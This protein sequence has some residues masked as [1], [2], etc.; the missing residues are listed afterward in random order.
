MNHCSRI[1]IKSHLDQWFDWMHLHSPLSIDISCDDDKT[2]PS[3]RSNFADSQTTRDARSAGFTLASDQQQ[4][5]VNVEWKSSWERP[6]AFEASHSFF[7]FLSLCLFA[8]FTRTLAASPHWYRMRL[9]MFPYLIQEWLEC[10]SLKSEAALHFF[11]FLPLIHLT[12]SRDHQNHPLSSGCF[13]IS[14]SPIFF[15]SLSLPLPLCPSPSVWFFPSWS[16]NIVPTK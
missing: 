5:K 8:C 13:F 12:H 11:L 15:L 6:V 9:N 2:V 16:S 10:N 14:L 7:A 3:H 1:A 4:V